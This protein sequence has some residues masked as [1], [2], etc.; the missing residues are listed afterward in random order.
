MTETGRSEKIKAIM[1][2]SRVVKFVFVPRLQKIY[3]YCI[4]FFK[5]GAMFL[6]AAEANRMQH[7][8]SSGWKLSFVFIFCDGYVGSHRPQRPRSKRR[9]IY[10]SRKCDRRHAVNWCLL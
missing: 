10:L 3:T 6:K 2:F 1:A 5:C 4:Y 8:P 9:L 7:R